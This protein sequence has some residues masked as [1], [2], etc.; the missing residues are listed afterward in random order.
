MLRY[1]TLCYVSLRYVMLCYVTLRYVVLRFITLRYV[2][3]CYV[4][5]RYVV[6]RFIT[7]RY[8]MLC[9]VID[10]PRSRFS[11]CSPILSNLRFFSFLIKKNKHHKQKPNT[12]FPTPNRCVQNSNQAEVLP[13]RCLLNDHFQRADSTKYKIKRNYL[14]KDGAY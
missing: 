4:T 5:L 2:M 1:V 10:S 9:Y 13:C 12:L 6:L 11:S 3:L 8:V 7:L 14:F